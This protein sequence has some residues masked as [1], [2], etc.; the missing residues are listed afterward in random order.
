MR[1]DEFSDRETKARAEKILSGVKTVYMGTNGSHGH[2][3][4]RAMSP[5]KVEG[6]DTL[7]FVADLNSSKII[8][9]VKDSKAVIYALGPRNAA[10]CRLWGSVTILDDE[11]SKKMVWSDEYKKHLFPDG[12]N[13]SNM[14]VLR[15]DVSNGHYRGKGGKYGEFKN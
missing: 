14:R 9:L 4:V 6:A 2:P 11:A 15:F 13:S 5:S 1:S 10:E 12:V 8:E 3:N 7:W